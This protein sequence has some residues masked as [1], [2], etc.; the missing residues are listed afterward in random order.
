MIIMAQELSLKKKFDLDAIIF[1]TIN[2]PIPY[3]SY[4]DPLFDAQFGDKLIIP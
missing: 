2:H 4:A 3:Y 1:C